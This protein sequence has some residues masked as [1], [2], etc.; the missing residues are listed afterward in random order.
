MFRVI[1]NVDTGKTRKLLEECARNNGV[2]VCKHP[3]R[4]AEKCYAYG[5]DISNIK[6]TMNYAD[7]I[8]SLYSLGVSDNIY[9]DELDSFLNVFE[10]SI[11][12]Y[13]IT[14]ED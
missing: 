14:V 3:E 13:S 7:Y 1:G 10:D 9:I 5:I 6:N 2:F 4:I 8:D 12:G 11:K